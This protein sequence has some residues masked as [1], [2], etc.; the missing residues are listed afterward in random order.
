[1]PWEHWDGM[2]R[3]N[4]TNAENAKADRNQMKMNAISYFLN[5]CVLLIIFL[6]PRYFH[7]DY[8]R[9]VDYV[10]IF[11][12][13][14][15]YLV[16]RYAKVTLGKLYLWVS[17]AQL[18]SCLLTITSNEEIGFKTTRIQY[19][20]TNQLH[21]NLNDFTEGVLSIAIL[22]YFALQILYIFRLVKAMGLAK[23]I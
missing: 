13:L 7:N 5:I 14:F 11:F 20:I 19:L 3:E 22:I 17:I 1:M 2:G 12:M 9:L 8:T 21:N 10:T 6:T 16:L 15:N 18:L 23:L 4:Q